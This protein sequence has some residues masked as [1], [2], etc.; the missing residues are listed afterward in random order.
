[1][2]PDTTNKTEVTTQ[3]LSWLAS[4]LKWEETLEALRHDERET[5]PKAA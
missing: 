2:Q 1:M 5:A 3:A 4:Q